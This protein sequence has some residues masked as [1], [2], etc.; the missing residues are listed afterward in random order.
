ME[1]PKKNP[2][3]RNG[4]NLDRSIDKLFYFTECYANNYLVAIDLFMRDRFVW[5]FVD[6]VFGARKTVS[7][8]ESLECAPIGGEPLHN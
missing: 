3:E 6:A 4:S 2:R 7:L 8:L 1:R 5:E